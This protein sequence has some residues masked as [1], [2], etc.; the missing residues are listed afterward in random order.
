VVGGQASPLAV[1]ETFDRAP[2]DLVVVPPAPAPHRRRQLRGR[3]I[4]DPIVVR[5]PVPLTAAQTAI[6]EDRLVLAVLRRCPAVDLDVAQVAATCALPPS[7]TT[8]ALHRLVRA[9]LAREVLVRGR[10]RFGLP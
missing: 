5:L 4:R 2:A 7:V 10:L 6:P 3:H 1:L 9:G 8:T